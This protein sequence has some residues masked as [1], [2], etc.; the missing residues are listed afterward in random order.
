MTQAHNASHLLDIT[1][2]E[3][4]ND[5]QHLAP[6][7]DSFIDQWVRAL[8]SGHLIEDNIADELEQLKA[9]LHHNKNL[10][11]AESLHSLAKLT[12]SAAEGEEEELRTKLTQMADTL[13]GLATKMGRKSKGV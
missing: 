12:K 1:L 7:A 5:P 6:M 4:G 2:R 13:E 9:A 8:G 3:L 10:E 11:I